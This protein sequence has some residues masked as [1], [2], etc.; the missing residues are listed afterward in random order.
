VEGHFR[1]EFQN[2]L[3]DDINLNGKSDGFLFHYLNNLVAIHLI[4]SCSTGQLGSVLS[5][6][7]PHFRQPFLNSKKNATP[8]TRTTAGKITKLCLDC[9]FGTQVA[10]ASDDVCLDNGLLTVHCISCERSFFFLINTSDGL[11]LF[12]HSAEKQFHE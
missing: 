7:L 9:P 2:V 8:A 3:E 4:S 1:L 5:V 12:S 10:K 11:E 6:F